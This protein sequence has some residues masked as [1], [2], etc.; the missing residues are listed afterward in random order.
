M[1]DSSSAKNGSDDW[2]VLAVGFSQRF[3]NEQQLVYLAKHE[4][5]R[6]GVP[7]FCPVFGQKWETTA[8]C[9][10]ISKSLTASGRNTSKCLAS[11]ISNSRALN[12]KLTR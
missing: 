12:P 9:I 1:R 4:V 3:G 10:G 6:K 8:A 11:G 7:H 2:K 5:P